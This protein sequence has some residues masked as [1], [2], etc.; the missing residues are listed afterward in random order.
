MKK[1][2]KVTAETVQVNRTAVKRIIGIDSSLTSLGLAW[3]EVENWGVEAVTPYP[4]ECKAVCASASLTL[5]ERYEYAMRAVLQKIR[6]WEESTLVLMENYAFGASNHQLVKLAG[7][8]EMIRFTTWKRTGN[9][10]V[11]VSPGQIKKYLG[12]RGNLPKDEV[13]LY[14]YKRFRKEFSTTDEAE[15]YSLTVMGIEMLF[16]EKFSGV[17]KTRKAL[18]AEIKKNVEI[19][20]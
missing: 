18:F 7:L 19:I 13:K 15:A 4:I 3:T 20:D 14:A 10:P 9:T 17:S 12:G 8:G 6:T 11:M 16:P 2:K 5:M 1:P